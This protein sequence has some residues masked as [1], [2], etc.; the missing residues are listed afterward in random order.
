[1][2]RLPRPLAFVL[3]LFLAVAVTSG[4]A[5][6]YAAI[7]VSQA[8][9]TETP[10]LAAQPDP[11][12]DLLRSAATDPARDGLGG[13]FPPECSKK[14]DPAAPLPWGTHCK[15]HGPTGVLGCDWRSGCVVVSQ[16]PPATPALENICASIAFKELRNPWN[17]DAKEAKRLGAPCQFSGDGYFVECTKTKCVAEIRE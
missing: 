15:I 17:I 3:G 11:I 12:G 16:A 6:L 14:I 8:S 1:M 9:A 4:L 10:A 5:G 2:T 7:Y 13:W